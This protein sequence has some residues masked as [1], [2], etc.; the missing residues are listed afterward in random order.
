MDLPNVPV[1]LSQEEI[2]FIARE[3]DAR[4]IQV[5]PAHAKAIDDRG[6]ALHFEPKPYETFDESA[7]LFGDGAVVVVKLPGHTPGSIGTFV[8]MSSKFRLFHGGMR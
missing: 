7:D 6:H 8:S 2:D 1:L 4:T 5:V 3:R